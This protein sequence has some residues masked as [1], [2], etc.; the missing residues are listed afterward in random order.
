MP[1]PLLRALLALVSSIPGG[2]EL[3]DPEQLLRASADAIAKA[4]S[5]SYRALREPAGDLQGQLPSSEG[6][7]V[8]ARL[9]E[10]DVVGARLWAQGVNRLPQSGE[11]VAFTN[12]YDGRV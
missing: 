9:P 2:R 11:R 4:G 1:L 6:Q 7:V 10:G 5:F 12:T 8:L 3:V